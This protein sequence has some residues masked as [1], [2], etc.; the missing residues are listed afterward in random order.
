MGTTINNINELA[1]QGGDVVTISEDFKKTV[2]TIYELYDALR[3]KWT[4][5]KSD[6]YKTKIE[7]LREPL[8]III[9]TVGRQGSAVQA[10]AEALQKFERS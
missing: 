3:D 10:A 8:Q 6:E 1:T 9:S 7:K 2:E 5:E 4:G